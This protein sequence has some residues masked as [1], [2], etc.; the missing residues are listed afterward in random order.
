MADSMFIK[1]PYPE[2][3]PALSLFKIKGYANAVTD[4][5]ILDFHVANI[6]ENVET[7]DTLIEQL[8][9]TVG[10]SIL[11]EPIYVGKESTYTFF[12]CLNDNRELIT[13]Q[14]KYYQHFKG[15]YKGCLFV[16]NDKS[17]PIGVI[18]QN[19]LVGL[20]MPLALTKELYYKLCHSLE[21]F[22]L[23]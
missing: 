19:V 1:I 18:H 23:V 4:H 8:I 2:E 17:S 9:P 3:I 10:K 5:Y 20:F 11:S 21:V 13:M 6:G 22:S 14:A 7:I 15:K 12:A 16:S